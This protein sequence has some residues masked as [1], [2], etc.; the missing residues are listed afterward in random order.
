VPADQHTPADY[1]LDESGQNPALLDGG[2]TQAG[3]DTTLL[4]PIP[5]LDTAKGAQP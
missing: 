2:E 3:V 4:P 5:S 1:L